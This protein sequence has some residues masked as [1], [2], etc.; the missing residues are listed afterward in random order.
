[1]ISLTT[2][3]TNKDQGKKYTEN[4]RDQYHYSPETNRMGS[5]IAIWSDDSLYH[6][7]YQYNPFN[8]MSGYV[9][10]GHAT[11][12]DLLHWNMQKLAISQS[13]TESDSMRLSPWWGSVCRIDTIAFAWYTRWDDGMYREKSSDG[14]QWD[15]EQLLIGTE[16]LKQC[17]PYVFWYVPTQKWVMLAYDRAEKK[18]HILNSVDG[19]NWHQTSSFTYMHGYPQLVEMMV[20]RK[21]DLTRWVL[22]TEKGTYALGDF[23]GE[24]FTINGAVKSFNRGKKV[25]GTIVFNDQ[26]NKR[27]LALSQL[28]SIQQADLPSNGVLTFPSEMALHQFESG[29][30]LVQHPIG[31]IDKLHKKVQHWEEEKVYPGINNNILKRVKG[32]E[33]HLKGEI[34][35]LNSDL[36]GFLIRCNRERKGNEISYNA[37]QGILTVM[38]M[39]MEY[40]PINNKL[41]FD[42]L[43][44]RSTVELYLDGG[45]YVFSVPFSPIPESIRYELFTAGGEIKVKWLDVYEMKSIWGNE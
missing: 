17:E 36:C 38:G 40:K 19:I 45:R 20:D 7:Y 24:N 32:M 9:N 43:I 26:K 44:D 8:L 30:E 22:V 3:S 1:M 13:A 5:P 4:F 28:E 11:S 33:L 2:F 25:D 29:I 21:P 14:T 37:K 15:N 6:L 10:W 16:T 18:M 34:E 23:D 42:I 12:L 41:E 35:V 31:E 39:Q 27:V